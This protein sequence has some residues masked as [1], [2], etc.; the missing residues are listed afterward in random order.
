MQ[1]ERGGILRGEGDGKGEK[2]RGEGAAKAK[3]D[4]GSAGF[5]G[6]GREE[7]GEVGG[8]EGGRGGTKGLVPIGQEE[9]EVGRKETKGREAVFL[10]YKLV[11]SSRS[12]S[13]PQECVGSTTV[14]QTQKPEYILNTTS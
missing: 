5:D 11:T 12:A 10:R 13:I 2:G 1:G 6:G 14:Q 8:G 3:G 7:G 9:E 4:G